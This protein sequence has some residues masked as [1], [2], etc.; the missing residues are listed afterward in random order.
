MDMH[1]PADGLS[2]AIEQILLLGSFFDG[3]GGGES[4][5]QHYFPINLAAL[6]G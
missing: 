2:D 4:A 3:G 6:W 5:V 1:S